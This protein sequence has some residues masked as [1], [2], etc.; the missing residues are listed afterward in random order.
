MSSF[1]GFSEKSFL[2][3][4]LKY[5]PSMDSDAIALY[6]SNELNCKDCFKSDVME[7]IQILGFWHILKEFSE[8][9]PL[10]KLFLS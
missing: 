4:N 10:F 6:F 1:T 5:G 2:K 7:S 8:G 3:K 9:L